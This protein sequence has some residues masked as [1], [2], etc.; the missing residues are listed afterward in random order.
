MHLQGRGLGASNLMNRKEEY[1]WCIVPKIQLE[2]R[3]RG[4]NSLKRT[5]EPVNVG[6]NHKRARLGDKERR[7]EHR[8]TPPTPTV[9]RDL[10][11]TVCATP[12]PKGDQEAAR[13]PD[14]DRTSRTDC[15]ATPKGIPGTPAIASHL[16]RTERKRK[17]TTPPRGIEQPAKDPML[18][19]ITEKDCGEDCI[20]TPKGIHEAT[21]L[22]SSQQPSPPPDTTPQRANQS[23]NKSTK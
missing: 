6:Q 20:L 23:T 21:A 14:L 10:S 16:S 18:N 17:S 7:E 11:R 12:T 13:N 4:E 9:P 1:N 3:W 5:R 8:E 2:E 22:A 15:E 19:R